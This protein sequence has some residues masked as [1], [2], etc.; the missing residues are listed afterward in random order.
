MQKKN[1]VPV[2]DVYN[3]SCEDIA[4]STAREYFEPIKISVW[5]VMDRQQANIKDIK[6]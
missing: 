1:V 4:R 2:L 3:D 5:Y 6:A